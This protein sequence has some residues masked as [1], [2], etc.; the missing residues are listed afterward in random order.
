MLRDGVAQI[1]A[2]ASTDGKAK[3]QVK[4][5]GTTMNSLGSL[6]RQPAYSM[7]Q[8]SPCDRSGASG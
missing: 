8:R 5:A 2:A 3:L 4:L 7:S 1:A 6:T